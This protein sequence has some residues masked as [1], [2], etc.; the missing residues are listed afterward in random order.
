[1]QVEEF[2]EHSAEAYPDKVALVCGS[3]RVTYGEIETAANQLARA[4]VACGLE[5]WDRVVIYA[6]NS[7]ETVLAIF[8]VLK[9]RGVFVLV[10]PT[11]KQEKLAYILNNSRAS[12]LITTGSLIRTAAGSAAAAPYLKAVIVANPIAPAQILGKEVISMA[13]ATEAQSGERPVQKNID[14]DL[15]ALIYTSGSTGQA[16][17][18]M[19]THLN[20]VSAATSITAYLENTSDDII[21]NVLP[22]SFDYGLYQLLMAFKIGGTLV[23]EQSFTYRRTILNTLVRE[24]VS[25][26]P[27]VPT[28]ASILLQ[29]DLAGYTFPDLRYITN[30]AAALP[31]TH[32][33]KLREAFPRAKIFSMYGLTECKRV[34][35][36]PPDQLDT[37]P[38]S[39]GRGMPNEE[40]YV[41]DELGNR[42]APN[43]VGELVIRGANV[44]KGYWELPEETA[45]V[46][47]PGPFPGE[48][49]L[50]S[51]DL[52]RADE[53]GYLYFV[54]RKDDMIKT[55]G[56][57]VSP[58]EVEN[59]L[60]S[61]PKVAEAAV[62]GV[63][64]EVLGSAICAFVSPKPGEVVSEMELRGFCAEHLEDFMVPQMVQFRP[65]LPKSANGKIAKRELRVEVEVPEEIVA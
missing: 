48:K 61:H 28:I 8:A 52:F 55:R 20:I 35:Y 19:L 34:S 42:V 1:M 36:L 43:I 12:V 44:M 27:I 37:R 41:V 6:N 2:L 53:D 13:F 60:Y 56:E 59:V 15:A 45:K 47:R 18:V 4:L 62:I 9:A 30:T 46:L 26:F 57:K 17:G 7:V 3:R 40:V 65:T 22:L 25:G 38:E 58:R 14:V 63:P 64:D 31:V 24:H 29:M 54:G 21:L 32:I 5:R 39:V 16:K 51:G 10:N 11:T 50:Y 23:L 33:R 49:V